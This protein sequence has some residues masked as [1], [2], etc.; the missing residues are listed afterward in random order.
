MPNRIVREDIITSAAVDQ[1]GCEAENFYRRLMSKVDDHGLY[2]ARPAILRASLYPLKLDK[3]SE[4]DC[5]SWLAE[6]EASGL[7]SRYE[8]AGQPYL[9][10]HKTKWAVRSEP[11]YPLPQATENNCAQP[12]TIAPLFV[13]VDV[14]V[15]EDVVVESEQAKS[16]PAAVGGGAIAIPLAD[17]SEALPPVALLS[18]LGK[19]YPRVNI[20]AEL[21]KART[22]CFANPTKKKTKGGLGK[23]LNGWMDRAQKN[24]PTEIAPAKP[25]GGRRAL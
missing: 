1:L 23:F 2:D 16:E 22:W 5:S 13:V 4:A 7:V 19:A 10:L 6:C 15:V 25:G 17:G 8:V 14:D 18:E 12:Q 21:A 11:K 3:V 9:K 20:P 24:A